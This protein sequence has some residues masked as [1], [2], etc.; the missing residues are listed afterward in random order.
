M[1]I[2][3]YRFYQDKETTLGNVQI[4]GKHFCTSLEDQYQDKKVLGETRIPM[5]R[6]EIKYRK[7]L[8]PMT[9]RY[10]QR[11]PWFSWHLELQD[12]PEFQ[13]VY[14]HIGNDDDDTEGCLLVG[15]GYLIRDKATLLDSTKAYEALYKKVSPM[16]DDGERVF[17]EIYNE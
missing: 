9:E 15:N 16:L 8:S 3:L 2:K 12:V 6:Y 7:V 4:N 17:I 1:L 13:Y 5:G 10:R 14:I 11:F